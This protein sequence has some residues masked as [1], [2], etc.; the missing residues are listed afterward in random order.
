[1]KTI[2]CVCFALLL[3]GAQALA[4]EA[5][6][7]AQLEKRYKAI[8]QLAPTLGA[9]ELFSFALNAAAAQWHP[10][11]ID[12][13]FDLAIKMQDRDA[14]SKTYGNL[15]W[16]WRDKGP[17]DLNAVEFCMQQ[18][19]LIRMFYKDNL[20]AAGREK[21]DELIKFGVE[22]VKRRGVKVGYTN[23]F[24]MHIWNEIAIGENTGRPE[25]A[26]QGYDDFNQ[27]M[28]YTLKHG[29]K[30]YNTTTYYG[31]DLDC[32]GL[33]AKYAQDAQAKKNAE[34]ALRLLW[35]DI[36][37]NFYA[38]CERLGGA[39][40]RDYDYLTGHGA[41]DVH[42]RDAGWLAPAGKDT[43]VFHQYCAWMPPA[44][45][46]AQFEKMI[47]RTIVQHWGEKPHEFSTSYMGAHFCLGSAG[48]SA[49]PED[50]ALTINFS[51]GPKEVMFNFVM[52]GRSDPYGTNKTAT[53]GGHLK[54]HH[55]TPFIA[56]VQHGPEVLFL[57]SDNST[58]KKEGNFEWDLPVMLSHLVFPSS[59][60][61]FEL[62]SVE[63]VKL[64]AQKALDYDAPIFLRA[65]DVVVAIKC[66]LATGATDG[67]ARLELSNDGAAHGASRLT[68]VHSEHAPTERATIAFC[69]VIGE[70]ID[71]F[72]KF[73]SVRITFAAM[74]KKA[75][76]KLENGR[77]ELEVP[78]VDVPGLDGALKLSANPEKNQRILRD[79]GEAEAEKYILGVNGKEMAK[80]IL[81]AAGAKWEEPAKKK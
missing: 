6:D 7:T 2:F 4:A 17:D 60:Q 65:G 77:V 80:P 46:R 18:A 10:E 42:L 39:H 48:A 1:M 72:R 74:V 15:K 37:A 69:I 58:H 55:L 34:A 62:M 52:D 68:W 19:I 59:L 38:P 16:Y 71:D 26:K 3:F 49:G 41:L 33:I 20:S 81:E 32:L 61:V 22:G 12:E 75:K 47:P 14:Q 27:W 56:S 51:S 50:K 13:V 73:D 54:S 11:R 76:V 70:G 67:H 23:I 29:V 9:R 25:F 40:S 24:L 43:D 44:E 53:G 57:A 78:G 28:A 5:A 63:P 8:Q 30:E 36:A 35:T 31:V 79:G 64:E 66:L 21:L 45:I